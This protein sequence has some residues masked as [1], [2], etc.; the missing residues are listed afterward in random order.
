M[1]V[2][3]PTAGTGKA[4][5]GKPWSQDEI[6]RLRKAYGMYVNQPRSLC[7][8]VGGRSIQEIDAKALELG[9]V[10]KAPVRGVD[11]AKK[12]KKGKGTAGPQGN[13][14]TSYED[15]VLR[16]NFPRFGLNT[17]KWDVK[18]EGRSPLSIKKRAR[19]LGL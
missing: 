11:H 3:A 16:R 5:G 9:L 7:L 18:L 1:S 17:G 6:A 8:A 19:K 13:S 4:H 12:P 10:R 2:S 15:G 14:W